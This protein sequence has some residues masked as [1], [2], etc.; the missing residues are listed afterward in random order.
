MGQDDE[1]SWEEMLLLSVKQNQL[2]IHDLSRQTSQL[3]QQLSRLHKLMES[4]SVQGEKQADKQVLSALR[5][6]LEQAQ[7]L[8]QELQTQ[9]SKAQQEHEKHNEAMHEATKTYLGRLSSETKALGSHRMH[10]NEIL[11][12]HRSRTRYMAAKLIGLAMVVG[13]TSSL[14]MMAGARYLLFPEET[15]KERIN[16]E[17][18]EYWQRSSSKLNEQ[19]WDVV[20]KRFSRNDNVMQLKLVDTS[21]KEESKKK[22]S[23]KKKRRNKK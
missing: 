3:N 13:L 23:S 5:V 12:S 9:N 17:S 1:M 7:A 10:L 22:T 11:H 14:C 8:H 16:R 21:L 19:E 6:H 15:E 20:I 18:C 2:E 4:M